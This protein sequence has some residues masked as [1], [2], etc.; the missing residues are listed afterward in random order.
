MFELYKRFSLREKT[1]FIGFIWFVLLCWGSGGISRFSQTLSGISD[2]RKT[3][4]GQKEILSRE[5]G[6]DADLEAQR[7][8]FDSSSTYNKDQLFAR[9]QAMA[10]GRASNIY[11]NK[12]D[13]QEG[14]IFNL[15]TVRITFRDQP[16]SSLLNF[17]QAL[18][19]EPYISLESATIAADTK[20]PELLDATFII[21]SFELK[22]P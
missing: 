6:I 14:G 3:I 13:V 12:E 11:Q 9:V 1:L 22:Q 16:I 19:D 20:K 17:D 2:S 8:K 21:T 15:H 4:A 5:A 7:S 10:E 18:Q